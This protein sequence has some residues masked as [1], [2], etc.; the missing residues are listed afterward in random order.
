MMWKVFFRRQSINR[1]LSS[2]RMDRIHFSHN[3]VSTPKRRM[4]CGRRDTTSGARLRT[5]HCPASHSCPFLPGPRRHLFSHWHNG[6]AH[7][8]GTR[9]WAQR[10]HAWAGLGAIKTGR[11]SKKWAKGDD[12]WIYANIGLAMTWVYELRMSK[13]IFKSYTCICRVK[14]D[15]NV[16]RRAM[17]EAKR[18]QGGMTIWSMQTWA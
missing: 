14:R 16:G 3:V 10:T 6:D 18:E 9:A 11:G 5:W 13:G 8:H 4:H 2:S 17:K 1:H 12:N 15:K 7:T